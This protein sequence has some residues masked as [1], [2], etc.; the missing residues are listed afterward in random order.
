MCVKM[1]VI[2]SVCKRER[3]RETTFIREYVCE[4]VCARERE[5]ER[6]RK[7]KQILNTFL[8]KE[9]NKKPSKPKRFA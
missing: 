8:S 5:R 2:E 3:Q 9:G 1:N 7:E 4:R 6:K